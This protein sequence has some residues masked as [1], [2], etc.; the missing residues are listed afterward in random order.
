MEFLK[1]L[2]Q[3]TIVLKRNE[4]LK[5]QY[6]KDT[7]VY[8]IEQGSLI[9]YLVNENVEQIIRFG[10]D[11][12]FIVALDS[13]FTENI[14]PFE[15][16]A[17]K[18][19]VLKVIPK[20]QIEEFLEVD[21]NQKFWIQILENLINQQMER[22]IDVLTNSPK[23]RYLRVMKRSPKVFQFIPLKYIANYLRMTP[24]TLSRLR[25]S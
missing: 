18:K 8:F 22:E 16:K 6:T 19:T 25:K 24:E 3:K 20:K 2:A 14:S 5:V 10:Y 13:F 23:E 1:N 17:I 11:G 4:I 7:N 12:N 21:S 15:I 9:I